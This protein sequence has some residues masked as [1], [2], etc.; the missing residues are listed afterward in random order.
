MEGYIKGVRFIE[1]RPD[2]AYWKW[3][4]RVS[5]L[6]RVNELID[7]LIGDW[8][9]QLIQENFLPEDAEEIL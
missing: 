7:P 1:G 8:D 2:L 3:R 4:K 5:I 6:T 9:A